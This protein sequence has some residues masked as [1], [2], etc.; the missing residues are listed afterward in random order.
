VYEVRNRSRKEILKERKWELQKPA[1]GE[2]RS[3]TRADTMA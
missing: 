3:R 2:R 1:C